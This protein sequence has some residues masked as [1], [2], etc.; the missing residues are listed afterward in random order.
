MYTVIEHVE[1]G[2][3]PESYQFSTQAEALSYAYEGGNLGCELME[4]IS[5]TGG[6]RYIGPH[7]IGIER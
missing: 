1:F 2:K 6:V 7:C 5:P 4:V 3:K